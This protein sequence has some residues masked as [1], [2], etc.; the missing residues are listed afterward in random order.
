MMK[1]PDESISPSGQAGPDPNLASV[2]LGCISVTRFSINYQKISCIL[3]RTVLITF[4]CCQPYISI[5]RPKLWFPNY[6]MRIGIVCILAF[7]VFQKFL[8]KCNSHLTMKNKVGDTEYDTNTST[9]ISVRASTSSLEMTSSRICNHAR[10]S[11]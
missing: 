9:S 3:N 1:T 7:F 5:R 2:H 4:Q 6:L 11:S 8:I 10:K